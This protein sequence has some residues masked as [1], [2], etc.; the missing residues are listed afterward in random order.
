MKNDLTVSLP[1]SY[2]PT[3][4]EICAKQ[5]FNTLK[6]QGRHLVHFCLPHCDTVISYEIED[7]RRVQ[8]WASWPTTQERALEIAR[9]DGSSLGLTSARNRLYIV[10]DEISA[11]DDILGN[12]TTDEKFDMRIKTCRGYADAGGDCLTAIYDSIKRQLHLY[13]FIDGELVWY[14]TSSNFTY[15]HALNLAENER[16]RADLPHDSLHFHLV[17]ELNCSGV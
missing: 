15:Q 5:M 13:R 7:G 6:V 8:H 14:W 4:K 9:R 3:V 17:K 1:L 2:E 10:R 16:V 12:G 11:F